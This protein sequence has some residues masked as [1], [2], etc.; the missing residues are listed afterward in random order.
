VGRCDRARRVS[1]RRVYCRD[2]L[3]LV[4]LTRK[5]ERPRLIPLWRRRSEG[6]PLPQET[7]TRAREPETFLG[8]NESRRYKTFVRSTQWSRKIAPDTDVLRAKGSHRTLGVGRWR[9][10]HFKG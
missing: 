5:G 1:D 8:A 9:C 4:Q 7:R 6:C 2:G 3:R 10:Q